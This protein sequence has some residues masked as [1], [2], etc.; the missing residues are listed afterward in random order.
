[1]L[2]F[3][4]NSTF[5]SVSQILSLEGPL[6]VF[7]GH[8][9]ARNSS[10]RSSLYF[11]ALTNCPFCNSFLLTFMHR[12]GG[13]GGTFLLALLTSNFQALTSFFS[14]SSELFCSFLH[15]FALAQNSTLLFSGDSKLFAKNT[16]G[17][18][19]P[20]QRQKR[21]AQPFYDRSRNLS[22]RV[23]KIPRAGGTCRLTTLPRSRGWPERESL[24]PLSQAGVTG[25]TAPHGP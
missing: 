10:S 15:F 18:V 17:G 21:R 5:Q 1:M 6:P 4:M 22:E 11:H 19:P 24:C 8:P 16:R 2:L 20:P 7:G 12:M 3:P 25:S 23:P 9:P 14:H 13:V